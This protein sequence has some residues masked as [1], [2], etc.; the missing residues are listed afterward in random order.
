MLRHTAQSTG[1]LAISK[2]KMKNI[3]IKLVN[4][5]E[6]LE[7]VKLVEPD[8]KQNRL[9]IRY[10][11]DFE[12]LEVSYEELTKYVA[13]HMDGNVCTLGLYM[14]EIPQSVF[15]KILE[16]INKN[17]KAYRFH[18]V[19][20]QNYLK[21]F[22]KK[23][24]WVLTLPNTFEEYEQKFS[25]KTRYNRR[26][27]KR[28]LEENYKCEW[29]YFSENEINKEM[30]SAFFELKKAKEKDKAYA[31]L[32][33]P[34]E[35]INNYNKLTDAYIL[36]INGQIASIVLYSIINPKVAFCHNMAFDMK[37]SKFNI[38]NE[39]YYYSIKDLIVRGIKK[40]YLGGGNYAY[41]KNSK[42][43]KF[44]S[45]TGD[46]FMLPPLKKIFSYFYEDKPVK[47]I[48]LLGLKLKFKI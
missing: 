35:Y 2:N 34:E 8:I 36:Y 3:S 1:I 38:G 40:I 44:Q 19:Q 10:N 12:L 25:A 45:Y 11:N 43:S 20:T 6:K 7:K 27:Y 47:R 30:I 23:V 28:M 15:E 26:R 17:K 32:V 13:F 33:N 21:G 37:Y 9:D 22:K 24:N 14:V 4:D 29:K 42:A 46:I 48:T 41:K 39:L 5:N 16:F 18:I 31:D